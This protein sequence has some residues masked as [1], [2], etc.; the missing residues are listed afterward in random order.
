MDFK[1]VSKI[2]SK[3]GEQIT[4][5]IQQKLIEDNNYAS[6]DSYNSVSHNNYIIR[7]LG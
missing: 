3:Y 1:G 5:S 7:L 2:L 6:G 4:S